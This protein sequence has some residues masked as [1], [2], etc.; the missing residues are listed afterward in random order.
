[1]VLQSG[2]LLFSPDIDSVWRF[3]DVGKA[4]SVDSLSY[5]AYTFHFLNDSVCLIAGS[6]NAIFGDADF[7][8]GRHP[9]FVLRSTN[10]GVTWDTVALE[11]NDGIYR[12]T[13]SG[14]GE[15][16]M[17]GSSGKVHY[18]TDNGLSWKV[19]SRPY[20]QD[21]D[22]RIMAIRIHA[23]FGAVG[24]DRGRVKV[25]YDKGH[26]W[27]EVAS[28]C[29]QIVQSD[30]VCSGVAIDKIDILGGNIV[31]KQ[32]GRCFYSGVESVDW[33]PFASNIIDFNVLESGELAVIDSSLGVVLLDSFLARPVSVQG[34]L[35]AGHDYM[36][37]HGGDLYVFDF[38]GNVSRISNGSVQTGT[39]MLEGDTATLATLGAVV[40]HNDV[41]FAVTAGSIY[42]SADSGSTWCRWAEVPC[43]ILQAI[44]V[45]E[46]H[47]VVVGSEG[48]GVFDIVGGVSQR[49][50]NVDGLMATFVAT[51]GDDVVIVG[52]GVGTKGE[53]PEIKTVRQ[54][55]VIYHSRDR[56]VTWSEVLREDSV[57]IFNLWL[58]SDGELFGVGEDEYLYKWSL[59]V[60][61][62]PVHHLSRQAAMPPYG[63]W[64]WQVVQI[65]FCDSLQGYVNYSLPKHNRIMA[66][67]SSALYRTYDGGMV[68]QD[69]MDTVLSVLLITKR[70]D[71][72][73]ASN[74]SHIY[75]YDKDCSVESLVDISTLPYA[76]DE[77]ATIRWVSVDNRGDLVV[78]ITTG[79]LYSEEG[80]SADLWVYD[81]NGKVLRK[82]R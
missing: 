38:L 61:G 32:G 44:V 82:L 45:D 1:M 74:D 18:T 62:T 19:I 48:G 36:S 34:R 65:F 6:M 25:T 56:G 73:I 2:D 70:G 53:W 59:P 11:S 15:A 57:R 16:W 55:S 76:P 68:W 9:S 10:G 24:S 30:K 8:I 5:S 77:R 21:R 78:K 47:V 69:V 26:S 52:D 20:G 17:G 42:R 41:L 22:E 12:I 67:R 28:P 71:A 43:E 35:R 66:K 39:M 31:V 40:K 14:N 4:L 3:I 75:L 37:S 64:R 79:S 46:D 29:G 60:S 51:R 58:S 49:I 63:E 54:G 27:I 13:G 80:L 33:Q 23:G 81:W 50:A 7:P 72:I